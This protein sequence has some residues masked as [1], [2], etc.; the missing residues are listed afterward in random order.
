MIRTLPILLI[1]LWILSIFTGCN[2]T[3]ADRHH[4]VSEDMEVVDS[5]S[6]PE[7]SWHSGTVVDSALI[8]SYGIDKCFSI[9]TISDSIFMLMS[10]KSYHACTPVARSDLRYLRLLHYNS[11]EKILFGELICNRSIADDLLEIFRQLFDARYPIERMKLISNYGGNDEAS[12]TAN[13]TSCFNSRN[14]AG[15][16][17]PSYHSFGLA[18]D[19]NP[20]YNPYI[21]TRNGEIVRILPQ[22]AKYSNTNSPYRIV[23]GDLCYRL[24][25]AH[26]F[27]WGGSWRTVK[28]YQ[29]FEKHK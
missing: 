24:F 29:H 16:S 6:L 12:M 8:H 9:D 14:I 2:L 3:D 15:A 5:A 4:A 7:F 25:I 1:S 18:I 19:I 26:G 20:L 13:N 21:K 23:E 27:K 11:E 17:K 22:A 28:D 10:G